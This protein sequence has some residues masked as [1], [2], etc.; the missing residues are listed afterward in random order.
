M[1]T[2]HGLGFVLDRKGWIRQS[3]PTFA[4]RS[5]AMP[6]SLPRF[7]ALL[8]TLSLAW[9][10]TSAPAQAQCIVDQWSGA[11]PTDESFL[12]EQIRV[13]GDWM[14][15]S[16]G[17]IGTP[18]QVHL[19][20]RDAAGEFRWKQT[21]TSPLPNAAE[22]FG[23]GLALL[24]GVLAVGA[25]SEDP[26]QPPAAQVFLFELIGTQWVFAQRV[27]APTET[28]NSRFGLNIALGSL[29]PDGAIALVAPAENERIFL[30]QPGPMFADG[31]GAVYVFRRESGAWVFEAKLTHDAPDPS[32]FFG[33][34]VALSRTDQEIDQL[35]VGVRGDSAFGLGAGAVRIYERVATG[36]W[37]LIQILDPNGPI[38]SGQ[39]GGGLASDGSRLVVSSDRGGQA[40]LFSGRFDYFERT[41]S[42][43]SRIQTF[44]PGPDSL[45]INFKD[46]LD[47]SGDT[48][49]VGTVFSTSSAI[50]SGSVLRFLRGENGFELVGQSVP[51]FAGTA[52]QFGRSVVLLDETPLR[53]AV[54]APG[55]DTYGDHHGTVFQ[56]QPSGGDCHTFF[57]ANGAVSIAAPEDVLLRL[58]PPSG[59]E[60]S[61]Y[62]ILG[63]TS[64]T[65]PGIPV[66]GQTLPLVIDNY[67][68]QTLTQPNTAPLP[69]SLGVFVGA[70]GTALA[71]FS[72]P[73]GLDPA[74]AGTV[75]HQAYVVIDPISL[76][77]THASNALTLVLAP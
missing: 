64:G 73:G 40:S 69:E 1:S 9:G 25:P 7:C 34:R 13:S 11:A 26:V 55:D 49:L 32:D 28:N 67:F 58:E 37:S 65:E 52:G 47:L 39:F 63:S 20:Q 38:N 27:T 54:S 74:L 24:D 45:L 66:D 42:T 70:W 2:S 15:I 4:H 53:F 14:A 10:A 48:F 50:G 21:V 29:G 18:G 46:G 16:S 76:N 22:T 33:S 8:A 51:K 57:T 75:A 35:I 77:V 31:A 43:W 71:T 36:S 72:L 68:L 60:G 17:A 5:P 59:A 23:Q 41:G 12:G 61:F 19:L 62:F 44:D 6:R 30:P 56:Y 3:Y